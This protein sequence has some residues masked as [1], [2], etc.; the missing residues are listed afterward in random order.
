MEE[1]K[2]GRQIVVLDKDVGAHELLQMVYRGE[3]TVTPQQMQAA[4]ES[5]AYEKPKLTAVATAELDGG[6]FADLLDRAIERQER[7]KR[8]QPKMIGVTPHPAEE[9]KGSMARM[10]R[11]V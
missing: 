11:R 10:K 5:I 9:L 2:L 7:A 6:S 1:W 8:P 3:I 4:R